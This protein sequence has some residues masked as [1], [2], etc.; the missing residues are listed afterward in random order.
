ML[1]SKACEYGIRAM[2][3]MASRG[4]TEPVLVRVVADAIRIPSPF[5]SKIVQTLTRHGLMVSQKGPGGGVVL[6]RPAEAISVIEVVEAID[7]LDLTKTCVLGIPRCS[8]DE[9][10]PMHEQWGAIR[11]EIVEMLSSRSIAEFAAELGDRGHVLTRDR[12][13]L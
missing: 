9:P 6:G 3:Y 7:G 4:D 1:F 5:L 12:K 2:M 11:R 10:C 13:L 8:D